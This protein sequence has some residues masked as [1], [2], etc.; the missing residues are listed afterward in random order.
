MEALDGV[1]VLPGGVR[2]VGGEGVVVGG[3][4]EVVAWRG[5]ADVAG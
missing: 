2:A 1:G 5:G 4:G 3:V